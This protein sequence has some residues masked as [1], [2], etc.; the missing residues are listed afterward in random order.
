MTL[1][2]CWVI[3]VVVGIII[4]SVF[5]IVRSGHGVLNIDRTDPNK[6]VYRLDINDLDGMAKKKH[7]LLKVNKNADLSHK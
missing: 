1:W 2:L 5:W 4:T 3:G 7:I 6:D